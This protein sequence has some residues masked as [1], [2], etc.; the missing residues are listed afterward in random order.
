MIGLLINLLILVLVFGVA[1][2]II[3]L[4]PLPPPFGLVAQVVLA[5]I[6]L[7]ILV[8]FLLNGSELG[9]RGGLLR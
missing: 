9:W 2:W 3:T 4:I 8:N 6:L 5:L 7:I 1:W